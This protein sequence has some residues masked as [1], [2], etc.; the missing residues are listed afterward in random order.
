MDSV[1][2]V[3]FKVRRRCIYLFIYSNVKETG[4]GDERKYGCNEVTLFPTSFGDT[5]QFLFRSVREISWE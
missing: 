5:F 2:Q 1:H 4:E 3:I